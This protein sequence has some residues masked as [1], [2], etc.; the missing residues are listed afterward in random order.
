VGD[1]TKEESGGSEHREHWETV[2]CPLLYWK[3]VAEKGR[4]QRRGEQITKALEEWRLTSGI[5]LPETGG[6]GCWRKG[7]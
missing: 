1:L 2:I 7:L 3:E 4:V 6:G 5:F